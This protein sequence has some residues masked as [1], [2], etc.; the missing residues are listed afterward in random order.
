[1]N[2][3]ADKQLVRGGAKHNLAIGEPEF[4]REHFEPHYPRRFNYDLSYP[5]TK[6]TEELERELRKLHPKGHIVVTVGAKQALYAG[7]YAIRARN[8]FLGN[9]LAHTAPYWPTY[10]TVAKLSGLAFNGSFDDFEIVVNTTPNNPDGGESTE[11]CHI[12]DAAYAHKVY[13]WSGKTPPNMLSVW[14]AGKTLGSPGARVG[15]LV[16]DIAEIAELAGR[17]VEQTTS[18]VPTTSQHHVAAT[19]RNTENIRDELYAK[20]KRDLDINFQRFDLYVGKYID[21]IQPAWGDLQRRGMFAWFKAK[22]PE[23]FARALNASGIIMV[24]GKAC[25]NEVEGVYRASM[26]L[27]LSPHH[28]AVVALHDALKGA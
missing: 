16:T 12:W 27:A 21:Y 19:L 3:D 5:D 18:G 11:P 2:W 9:R 7:I 13:G 14:S 6:P 17:Y 25:G 23:K 8:G 24:S 20:A 1:M 15:W 28:T 4:L 22:D 26:G 10:P